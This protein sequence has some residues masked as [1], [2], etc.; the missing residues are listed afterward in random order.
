MPEAKRSLQ[1]RR[2]FRAPREAL[3]AA[4]TRADALKTWWGPEGFTTPRVEMDLRVGG[5][6]RVEMRPAEGESFH[7]NGEFLEVKPPERI[8][9]GFRWEKGDW[10]YPETRLTAEFL[11]RG[12]ET[13]LL[14]TH[15][16]FPDENMREEHESGWGECLDRLHRRVRERE[17]RFFNPGERA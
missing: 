4:W 13:E 12:D 3:F 5:K 15:E 2:T 14:L 6:Y 16:G 9:C 17:P 11:E 10:D 7:L 8:V 1:I